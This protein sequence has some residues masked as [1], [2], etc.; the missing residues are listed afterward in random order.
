[1]KRLQKYWSLTQQYQMY[2]QD[3]QIHHKE[4]MIINHQD[5]IMKDMD[6][7]L[8]VDDIYKKK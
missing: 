4:F 1:M 5:K 2:N 8:V 7:Y 6:G 3:Q